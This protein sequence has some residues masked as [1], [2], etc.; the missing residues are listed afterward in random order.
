MIN[1]AFMAFARIGRLFDSSRRI[2]IQAI[3]IYL[4]TGAFYKQAKDNRCLSNPIAFLN[5][6]FSE[7]DLTGPTLP[8][9]KSLLETSDSK[10]PGEDLKFSHLIHGLLSTCLLNIDQMRDREGIIAQLKIKNN[11]LA[12]VVVLTSVKERVKLSRISLEQC[13]YLISQRLTE[14]SDVRLLND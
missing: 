5:D 4:Y 1:S 9:L 13:C 12:A 7:Y 6:E 11:M 8:T 3:G 14:P 2:D 10:A